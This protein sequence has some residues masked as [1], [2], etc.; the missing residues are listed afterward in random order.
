M[1]HPRMGN[2]NRIHM[3]NLIHHRALVSKVN[4][5]LPVDDRMGVGGLGPSQ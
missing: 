2:V 3:R 4:S 1:N 5:G